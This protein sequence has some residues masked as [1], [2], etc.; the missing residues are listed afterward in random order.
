MGSNISAVAQTKDNPATPEPKTL[1]LQMTLP[2][3]PS[4][5]NSHF[6]LEPAL[7]SERWM[8]AGEA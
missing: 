4:S 2:V 3:E 8:V 6:S 5:R 1:S 7:K